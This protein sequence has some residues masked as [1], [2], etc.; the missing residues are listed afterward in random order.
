MDNSLIDKALDWAVVGVLGLIGWL[1][2]RFTGKI[3]ALD[4]K[5]NEHIVDDASTH[6]H[7]VRNEDL[8]EFK[9]G[10]FAR[11]DKMEERQEVILDKISIGINRDEFKEECR[12]IYNKLDFLERQKQDK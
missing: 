4:I 9:S 6:D 1:G 3:D 2:N 10:L 7:F 12:E 5:L 8:K 11:W